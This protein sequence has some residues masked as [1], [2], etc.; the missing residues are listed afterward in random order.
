MGYPAVALTGD[1]VV[2][3]SLADLGAPGGPNGGI[4]VFPTPICGARPVEHAT[5]FVATARGRRASR[6]RLAGTIDVPSDPPVDPS[7]NGLRILLADSGGAA[8]VDATLPSGSGWTQR[9][10]AWQF[11]DPTGSVAGIRRAIVRRVAG[12]PT[13]I[14]VLVLVSGGSYSGAIGQG[15]L[16]ATVV[17]EPP[18]GNDGQ[19]GDVEW[20]ATSCNGNMGARRCRAH[21]Q[22]AE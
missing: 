18:I 11:L 14:S 4:F 22:V 16:R 12:S 6:L 13:R 20:P 9:G 7:T 17:L 8:F 15:G 21:A 2:L 3:G 1:S 10:P 5:L 19:C